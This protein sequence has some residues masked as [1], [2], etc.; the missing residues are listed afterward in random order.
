MRPTWSPV[1]TKIHPKSILMLKTSKTKK[2]ENLKI[3]DFQGFEAR[4]SDV[5]SMFFLSRRLTQPKTPPRRFQDVQG[6]AQDAPERP[7]DAPRRPKIRPRRPRTPPRRPQDAAKTPQDDPKTVQDA[8]K[9]APRRPQ[10]TP[11]RPKTPQDHPRRSQATQ[12]HHQTT[13]LAG[14]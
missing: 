4:P 6:R 1:G 8:P 14:F 11:R 7:Q 2:N 13:I 10:D 9:T 5:K 12:N 3:D